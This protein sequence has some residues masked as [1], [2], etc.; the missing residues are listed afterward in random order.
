[1]KMKPY[2]ALL[3][4]VLNCLRSRS[5]TT[6]AAKATTELGLELA[7]GSTLSLLAGVT[8]AVA[9]TVTTTVTATSTTATTTALTVVTAEH[10]PGRSRALLLDVG[11]GNDLGREVEPFA[12]VVETLRGEGVVVPLPRE[13]G[14]EVTARGQRLASLDDVK[15]LGVDLAVLGKVEVLLSDQNSL[16]EEVLVDLL[17][18]GLGDKHFDGLRKTRE[19]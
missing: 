3:Q 2:L 13:A 12:E 1:M 11:L 15:V 5:S 10:T 8:A 14:L 9:V 17:A 18:V 16:S 4:K 7:R 6:S 19:C